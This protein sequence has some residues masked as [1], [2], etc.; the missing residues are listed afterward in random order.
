MSDEAYIFNPRNDSLEERIRSYRSVLEA[1]RNA[2]ASL[3]HLD[4]EEWSSSLGD[5]EEVQQAYEIA[6]RSHAMAVQSI[7]QVESQKA[8]EEGLISNAEMIEFTREKRQQEMSDLRSSHQESES[9]SHSQR[10]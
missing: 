9:S 2:E 6:K 5:K 10:R 7:S 3:E 4:D 8:K 1:L